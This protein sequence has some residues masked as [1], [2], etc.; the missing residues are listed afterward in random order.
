MTN[1]YLGDVPHAAV[2]T[3]NQVSNIVVVVVVVV[4]R[5]WDSLPKYPGRRV[6]AISNLN[7]FMYLFLGDVEI[8]FKRN[9]K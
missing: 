7:I 1:E 2:K 6:A 3:T 5:C 9:D 8:I 4:L